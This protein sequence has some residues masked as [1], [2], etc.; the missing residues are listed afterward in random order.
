MTT[1]LKTLL[2]T[3][4]LVLKRTVTRLSKRTQT[5]TY[6]NPKTQNFIKLSFARKTITRTKSGIL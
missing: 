5:M 2:R 1:Y 6:Y 4:T 3:K